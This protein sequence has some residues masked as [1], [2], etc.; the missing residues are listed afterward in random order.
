MMNFLVY[1]GDVLTHIEYLLKVIKE[2]PK[3]A[4]EFGC[5]TGFHFSFLSKFVRHLVCLDLNVKTLKIAREN[6]KKFGDAGKVSF[7]VEMSSTCHLD[8]K[9]L[10][11]RSP[12]DC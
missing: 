6:V 8:P 9:P 4:L 3:E 10:T 11:W 2:R 1:L 7:I 5:G 12:K